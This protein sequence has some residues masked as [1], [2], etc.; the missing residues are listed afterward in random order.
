[1]KTSEDLRNWAQALLDENN[2][3]GISLREYAEAWEAER[4]AREEECRAI[5]RWRNRAEA[6]EHRLAAIEQGTIEHIK[7]LFRG[8][9]Y[10][11]YEYSVETIEHAFSPNAAAAQ[12]GHAAYNEQSEPAGL[13]PVAAQY[14][15]EELERVMAQEVAAAP[16][17]NSKSQYKRLITQGAIKSAAPQEGCELFPNVKLTGGL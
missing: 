6:A 16:I 14:E 9:T 7:A 11:P 17:A 12:A 3:I 13:A 4:K 10:G 1:M 2:S 5:E 15:D 8:L